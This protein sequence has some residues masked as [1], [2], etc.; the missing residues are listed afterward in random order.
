MFPAT[1]ILSDG[2]VV[3]HDHRPNG[4]PK[5][6][7]RQVPPQLECADENQAGGR[8]AIAAEQMTRCWCSARLGAVPKRALAS[9]RLKRLR[10]EKSERSQNRAAHM[11]GSKLGSAMVSCVKVGRS[12]E[13]TA[14][15]R[16]A[17]P[18]EGAEVNDPCVFIRRTGAS[19]I[20]DAALVV[21]E[22][23]TCVRSG[24]LAL[25]ASKAGGRHPSAA[26]GKLRGD[27]ETGH[28]R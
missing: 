19:V 5:A 6:R 2:E 26:C 13:C 24:S 1:T 12:G 18:G 8:R 20:G 17:S 7:A 3:D 25:E 28:G 9:H 27:Q 16:Q 22:T 4:M 14:V 10:S 15:T 11:V 23:S 21:D